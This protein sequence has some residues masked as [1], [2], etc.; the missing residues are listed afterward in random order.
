VPEVV[1][2]ARF[3]L[4]V[5]RASLARFLAAD[6]AR[7]VKVVTGIALI[8]ALKTTDGAVSTTWGAAGTSVISILPVLTNS[9]GD[10]LGNTSES[11]WVNP[12]FWALDVT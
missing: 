6:F 3:A 9:T 2:E 11:G 8:A 10:V 12:L 1:R 7:V 4:L 5:N